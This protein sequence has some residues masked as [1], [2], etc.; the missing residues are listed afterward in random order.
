MAARVKIDYVEG[1]NSKSTTVSFRMEKDKTIWMSKLGFIKAM[2]TPDRVS[3][4]NKLD[5]TYFDGDYA[6]ISDILGTD[7]D[8]NKVQNLIL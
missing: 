6:L 1:E 7:L 2:I 4:Y 3:F 8:F 5:N